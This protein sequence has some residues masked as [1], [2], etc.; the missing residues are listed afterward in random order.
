MPVAWIR[1]NQMVCS[2]EKT[3]LMVIGTRELR[4]KKYE[5]FGRKLQVKIEN[6]MVEETTDEG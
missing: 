6:K 5:S 2:G 1:Y 3:K 4:G